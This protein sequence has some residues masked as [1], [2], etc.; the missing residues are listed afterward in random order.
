MSLFSFSRRV[1]LT[2]PSPSRRN[3]QVFVPL[4]VDDLANTFAWS[5]HSTARPES[6]ASF[7][8]DAV[9]TNCVPVSYT[10]LTLPTILLV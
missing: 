1:T 8:D 4:L 7:E 10:H 6:C 2:P 9:Q 5:R 3:A